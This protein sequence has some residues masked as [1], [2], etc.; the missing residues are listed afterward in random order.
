MFFHG[1]CNGRCS[2]LLDSS[3]A[4]ETRR[5]YCSISQSDLNGRQGPCHVGDVEQRGS[6]HKHQDQHR[7]KPITNGG[8]KPSQPPITCKNTAHVQKKKE[9]KNT[10]LGANLQT[11]G[12]A[13]L[14]KRPSANLQMLGEAGLC[15]RPIKEKAAPRPLSY[16]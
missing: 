14:C 12:E 10:L 8:W 5:R 2:T 3:H 13:G 16:C 15:K 7:N 1:L 4:C 9:K 6:S 11:L